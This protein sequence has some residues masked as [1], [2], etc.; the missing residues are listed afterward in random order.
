M[1]KIIFCSLLAT[2]LFS[3]GIG[4]GGAGGSTA[5][6]NMTPT[7]PLNAAGTWY[8][9]STSSNCTSMMGSVF[10]PEVQV[11]QTGE[12]I[13]MTSR[14]SPEIITSR[15]SSNGSF[16]YTTNMTPC[17]GQ[18]FQNGGRF[19]RG[20]ANIECR[21]GSTTCTS[22]YAR[23]ELGLSTFSGCSFNL[24]SLLNADNRSSATTYWQ[25]SFTGGSSDT[26][27][28]RDGTG[29]STAIGPFTWMQ[30]SCNSLFYMGT[31][32]GDITN[33]TGSVA[34]GILSGVDRFNGNAV[35]ISC[36][37]RNL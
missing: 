8:L 21:A 11:T 23:N 31:R 12:N 28:F 37:L 7:E 10:V 27:I 16:A 5:D 9:Q 17:T 15:L 19:G 2:I 13:T 30:T 22:V 1:K 14:V 36:V 3:G 6:F 34:S 29:L 26:S 33:I 24:S 20:Y 32:N 25:C 4:C 18:F 35:N